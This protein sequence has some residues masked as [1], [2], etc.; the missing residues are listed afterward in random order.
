MLD[1]AG[2]AHSRR[3]TESSTGQYCL[4]TLVGWEIYIVLYVAQKSYWALGNWQPLKK[5]APSRVTV[6][7]WM[8][9]MGDH[10]TSSDLWHFNPP[11][12]EFCRVSVTQSDFPEKNVF[13]IRPPHFPMFIMSSSKYIWEKDYSVCV[14]VFNIPWLTT[15]SACQNLEHG[16]YDCWEIR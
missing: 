1:S 5:D 9:V 8:A 14:C 2:G 11:Q 15:Y 13:L 7:F 3:R 16:M 12:T 6:L 10:W 4:E